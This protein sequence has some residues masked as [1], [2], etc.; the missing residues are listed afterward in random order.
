LVGSLDETHAVLAHVHQ[1]LVDI[2]TRCVLVTLDLS[3]TDTALSI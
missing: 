2:H 3:H 1:Y